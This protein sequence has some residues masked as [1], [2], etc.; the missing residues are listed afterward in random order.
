[1]FGQTKQATSA[2][3]SIAYLTIGALTVVWSVIYY[4]YL[5]RTEA[6]DLTFLWCYGFFFSGLVLIVIGLAVGRLG[7]AAMPAEVAPTPNVTV[8]PAAPTLVDTAPNVAATGVPVSTAPVVPGTTMQ[9]MAAGST[10]PAAPV[11]P[12]NVARQ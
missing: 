9:A 5:K 11:M 4:L 6:S 8:M 7:R 10:V 2:K 12:A 3:T 1:M